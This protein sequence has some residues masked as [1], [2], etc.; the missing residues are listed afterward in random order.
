LWREVTARFSQFMQALGIVTQAD[1]QD[2]MPGGAPA[3]S[4]GPPPRVGEGAPVAGRID[5]EFQNSLRRHRPTWLRGFEL[6]PEIAPT[7]GWAFSRA[8]W[9]TQNDQVQAVAA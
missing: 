6:D 8:G 4:L 5:F 2:G 9:W 3:T 1:E 7:M